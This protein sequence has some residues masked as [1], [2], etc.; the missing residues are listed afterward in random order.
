MTSHN[1]KTERNAEVVRRRLAGE[2]IAALARSYGVG[3]K[4]IVAILRRNGVGPEPAPVPVGY[5]DAAATA[6]AELFRRLRAAIPRDDCR[7]LTGRLL[8]DPLPNDQRRARLADAGRDEQR[9]AAERLLPR[10]AC[11]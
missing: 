4:S 8:G 1:T 6:D 11:L 3:R 10:L 9:R 7:D 5:R 2:T